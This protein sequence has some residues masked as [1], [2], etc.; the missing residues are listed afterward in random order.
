MN[1]PPAHQKKKKKK[2]TSKQQQIQWGVSI[3]SDAF[4]LPAK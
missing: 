4:T 3:K 1:T 2:K